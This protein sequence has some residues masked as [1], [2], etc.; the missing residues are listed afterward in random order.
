[1][2]RDLLLTV[3]LLALVSIASACSGTEPDATSPQAPTTAD[4]ALALKPVDH[5]S[6]G[7]YVVTLLN[8]TGAVTSDATRF[9]IEIRRGGGLVSVDNLLIQ[10]R[11][12]MAG[13]APMTGTVSVVAAHEPGRYNVAASRPPMPGLWKM[14]VTFDPGQRVELAATVH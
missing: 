4:S 5:Q 9:T 6:S 8:E 14:V 11:M 3:S 13:M 12:E 2:K 10:T 1:M 7:D